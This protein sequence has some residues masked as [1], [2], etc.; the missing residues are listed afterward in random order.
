MKSDID[1]NLKAREQARLAR[2]LTIR[3]RV[4]KGLAGR[5]IG[6]HKVPE[7]HID[8]QIGEDLAENLR[9]LKVGTTIVCVYICPIQLPFQAGGKFVPRSFREFTAAS[10]D[11]TSCSRAVRG[12]ISHWVCT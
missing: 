9:T 5:R 8:V 11:R 4:R 7:S 6:K 10:I 3:L 2:Q 12:S 1:K